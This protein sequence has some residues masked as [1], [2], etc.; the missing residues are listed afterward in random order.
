MALMYE[1]REVW[2][3]HSERTHISDL[4]IEVLVLSIKNVNIHWGFNMFWHILGY[5][6]RS[7]CAAPY[8]IVL[9]LDAVKKLFIT[10]VQPRSL[11]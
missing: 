2:N 4:Q 5:I 1:V 8:T 7:V 3:V 11:V 9:K 10:D 6:H